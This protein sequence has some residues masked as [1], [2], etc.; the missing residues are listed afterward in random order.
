MKVKPL[1]LLP[2]VIFA[3]LA[4][5]FYIGMQRDD[6]DQLPIMQHALMR[7]WDCWL[8]D[9]NENEPLDLRHYEATN[10]FH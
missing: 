8:G 10:L 2:P 5:M 4:A 3:G 1:M 6:P 9:H 7:T